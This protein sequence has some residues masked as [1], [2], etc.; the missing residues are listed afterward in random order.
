MSLQ[1]VVTFRSNYYKRGLTR[2]EHHFFKMKI[3]LIILSVFAASALAGVIDS[4]EE[5]FHELWNDPKEQESV[6][7]QVE[8]EEASIEKEN[9]AFA[10]GE[11]P[12]E[13][14]LN[15][16]SLIPKK[17]FEEEKTGLTIEATNK[18][19][20]GAIEVPEEFRIMSPDDRSFLDNLYANLS[21][22]LPASYDARSI[23]KVSFK[24]N[25]ESVSWLFSSRHHHSPKEPDELWILRCLL[26]NCCP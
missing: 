10:K 15:P 25:S 18:Y 7:K 5:E 17:E 26:S 22:A 21:R 16:I 3:T 6:E 12:F 23:G 19:F 11:A 1:T 9:E 24:N 20:T 2:D 13:E 14:Q 4:F 8:K